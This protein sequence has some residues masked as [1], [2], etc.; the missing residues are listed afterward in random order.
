MS[1]TQAGLFKSQVYTPVHAAVGCRWAGKALMILG[2]LLLFY[3]VTLALFRFTQKGFFSSP[4]LDESKSGEAEE[5][6][7]E[8]AYDGVTIN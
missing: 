4:G 8:S 7:L 3:R 1:D 5:S 6:L 2:G